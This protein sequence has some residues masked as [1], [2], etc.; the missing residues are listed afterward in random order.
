MVSICQRSLT[1]GIKPTNINPS[2]VDELV[3]TSN[4]AEDEMCVDFISQI[5]G[6]MAICQNLD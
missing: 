4:M 6:L 5:E 1:K 2:E 3:P